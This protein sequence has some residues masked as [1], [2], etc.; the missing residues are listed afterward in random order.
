MF[1]GADN[2]NYFFNIGDGQDSIADALGFNQIQFGAGIDVANVTS[3][4]IIAADNAQY[5]LI[6]YGLGD[7]VGIKVS[8]TGGIATYHFADGEALDREAFDKLNLVGTTK[9]LGISG[10]E[11]LNGTIDT[12]V[13]LGR[14]GNDT[15]NAG[16]GND[17]LSGGAGNDTLFGNGD[18]DILAGGSGDDLLLGGLGLDTYVFRPG[19]GNDTIQ[20]QLVSAGPGLGIYSTPLQTLRGSTSCPAKVMS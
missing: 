16:F 4:V 19:D 3:E 15:I 6:G 1:G 14:A 13:I 7:E 2:D 11:T 18:N 10:A 17:Y 5:L 8:A 12:D 20:K 9:T